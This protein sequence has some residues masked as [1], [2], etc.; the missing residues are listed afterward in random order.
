MNKKE[1]LA[2]IEETVRIIK[3]VRKCFCPNKLLDKNDYFVR[4]LWKLPRN[5]EDVL[6]LAKAARKFVKIEQRQ[7]RKKIK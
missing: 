3:L 4:E 2:K 6:Y 1:D 5:K 7:N